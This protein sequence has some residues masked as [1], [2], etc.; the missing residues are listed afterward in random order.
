MNSKNVVL[1]N[2]DGINSAGSVDRQ[3]GRYREK[4]SRDYFHLFNMVFVRPIPARQVRG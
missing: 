4:D 3:N 2:I 1:S